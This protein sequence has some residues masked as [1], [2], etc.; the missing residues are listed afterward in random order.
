MVKFNE[1]KHSERKNEQWESQDM[2]AGWW[3]CLWRG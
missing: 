3:D 1:D 2:V